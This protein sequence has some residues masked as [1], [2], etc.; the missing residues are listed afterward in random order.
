MFKRVYHGGILILALIAGIAAWNDPRTQE[1]WAYLSS[2]HH[3]PIEVLIICT[4]FLA[5]LDRVE[6][7]TTSW[8]PPKAVLLPGDTLLTLDRIEKV[9]W[10]VKDEQISARF[11][12]SS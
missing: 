3:A 12:R 11:P 6:K 4:F 7:L 2:G 1:L 10:E 9:L 5:F 8:D